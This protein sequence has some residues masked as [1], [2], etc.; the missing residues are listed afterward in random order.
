MQINPARRGLLTGFVFTVT[1]LLLCATFIV[2][3]IAMIPGAM[4]EKIA[5]RMVPNDPY[6]NV[7]LLTTAILM[8][9][10]LLVLIPA[11]LLLRSGTPPDEP[12]SR[13]K[14]LYIMGVLYFIVNPLVF[15]IYVSLAS[16]NANDGQYSMTFLI[17]APISSFVFIPIGILADAVKIQTHHH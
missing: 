9:L 14:L 16:N 13:L 10:F 5:A 17:T 4:V 12:Y 1:T 6:S 3:V 2:P 7:T 11:L 8:A 15:Y